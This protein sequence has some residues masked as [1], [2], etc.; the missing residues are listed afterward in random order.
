[1]QS[2]LPASWMTPATLALMT[3]VGPPDC[4]TKRLPTNSAIILPGLL[5]GDGFLPHLPN[6]QSLE[7]R[8]ETLPSSAS[9]VKGKSPDL[10]MVGCQLSVVSWS[11]GFGGSRLES[12]LKRAEAGMRAYKGLRR[13]G[14]RFL[15]DKIFCG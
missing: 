2:C 3:A 7:K 10:S 4:A 13:L 9:H 1:M 11:P 5:R 14:V 8:S 15:R 12:E 6:Y